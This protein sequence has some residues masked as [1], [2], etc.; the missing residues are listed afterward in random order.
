MALRFL[1]SNAAGAAAPNAQGS[2]SL[3]VLD[4]GPGASAL[5]ALVEGLPGS[6]RLDAVR[7]LRERA[8]SFSREFADFIAELSRANHGPDWW[9]LS[10]PGKNPLTLPLP[11]RAL[12]L[13]VIVETAAALP[14]HGELWVCS[15]DD[16]LTSATRG[17]AGGRGLPFTAPPP[18]LPE[19]KPLFNRIAPLGPLTA[20][21]RALWSLTLSRLLCPV[22]PLNGSLL[23]FFT[24]LGNSSIDS[25][26]RYTDVFFGKLIDEASR[27]GFRPLV[28]GTAARGAAAVHARRVSG[29]GP[30]V[31]PLDRFL[32]WNALWPILLK[33]LRLRASGYALR[34]KATLGELDLTDLVRAELDDNL[35][36]GRYFTDLWYGACARALLETSN[37]RALIY[38][39]E[40]LARE[41][42]MLAEFRSRAPKTVLV[43]YQHAS[44]T[45]NHLNLLMG[46]GEVDALPLPD[47]IVTTGETTLER[48]REWGRFPGSLLRAG[49]AL[50]Q[51]PPRPADAGLRNDS[52]R[53]RLLAAAATS[54]EELARILR[55]LDEAYGTNPPTWLEITI[56]P[57][58]L[59]PLASGLAS[60]G[61]VRFSYRD[62]SSG[63]LAERIREADA[64]AYV[65]STAGIEALA[66]GVPAI[67]LDLGHPFGIDPIE[68]V[69]GFKWTAR[70]GTQLRSAVESIRSLSAEE[71]GRRGAIARDWAARYLTPPSPAAFEAFFP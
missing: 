34:G 56:R 42:S 65:S 52:P 22:P 59:F 32:N 54:V 12:A 7:L 20:F 10:L 33:A 30:A 61:P 3:L 67:C 40:N 70:D 69:A 45:P 29:D 14:P 5:T 16:A 68:G 26:G 2:V 64:V 6:K 63:A 46:R 4:E 62:G 28:W 66:H 39:F 23:V 57:H 27:R 58:P 1:R 48:L 18:R 9:T 17:W 38:P 24:F 71:R 13:S 15:N 43:G 41:R 19:L 44:M 36:S 51:S 55:L 47:R 25:H 53:F 35:R 11:A 31:T 50:R 49:C 8:P 21:A 37:P 60:S